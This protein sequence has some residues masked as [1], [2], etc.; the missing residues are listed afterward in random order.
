MILTL[1]KWRLICGHA[2]HFWNQ[3]KENYALS[4][5]NDNL[6]VYPH[7][8]L[9]NRLSQVQIAAFLGISPEFL[10]RLRNRQSKTPKAK[11]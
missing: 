4:D 3:L 6:E 11:S 2:M 9:T 8:N 10:S 1:M 7:L 5:V